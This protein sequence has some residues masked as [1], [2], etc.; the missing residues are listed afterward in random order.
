MQKTFAG[1]PLNRFTRPESFRH[2]YKPSKTLHF[3][4]FPPEA[5]EDSVA[6]FFASVG[7]NPPVRLKFF[8]I[9]SREKD[10]RKTGLAEF[11]TLSE[12]VEAVSMAN[13]LP[14]GPYTS[15]LSFTNNTV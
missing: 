2:I 15:K 1:S 10:D 7:V 12:A 9:S 4:N 5:T 14:Q 8:D 11:S 13:N 6:K 3:S